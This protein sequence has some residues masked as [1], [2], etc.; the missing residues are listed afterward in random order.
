MPEEAASPLGCVEQ[1]QWC[2][3]AYSRELGCGPLAWMQDA[4]A[5]A[6][7]FFNLAREMLDDER[8]PAN[9]SA[10]TRLI[11]PALVQYAGS[12]QVGW[13]VEELKTSVLASQSVLVGGVQY[14]LPKN[15]WKLDVTNWWNTLLAKTQTNLVKSTI[16]LTGPEMQSAALAV[17]PVNDYERSLRNNQ[18]YRISQCIIP[19]HFNINIFNIYGSISDMKFRRFEA[20]IIRHSAS[21]GCALLIAPAL[22]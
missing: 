21:S 4:F 12:A 1:W 13:A 2:N 7:P 15:Q 19:C 20:P 9:T 16:G 22:L 10:G 3:S 11:W 6:L 17:T 14:P 18:V 5:G 8:P